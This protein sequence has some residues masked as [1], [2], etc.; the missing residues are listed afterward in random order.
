VT[1]S[2]ITR[3]MRLSAIVTL[4]LAPTYLGAGVFFVK[5]GPT[6]LVAG[7]FTTATLV[8]GPTP[9]L[10]AVC[11][12][13]NNAP[14]RL[15]SGYCLASNYLE[16]DLYF[17]SGQSQTGVHAYFGAQQFS[18]SCHTQTQDSTQG[19]AEGSRPPVRPALLTRPESERPRV[20]KIV[21]PA[22]TPAPHVTPARISLSPE[23]R[24][25]S[26][27]A[28]AAAAHANYAHNPAPPYEIFS[29]CQNAACSGEVQ[30]EVLP[31]NK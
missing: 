11:C 2:L 20:M 4:S 31:L 5:L 16:V 13:C 28:E 12:P 21:A 22:L 29:E 6:L 23:A 27:R 17:Q 8:H 19:A 7:S 26:T 9:T 15:D 30:T 24:R 14:S 25:G 18:T 3:A 1:H 10:Y